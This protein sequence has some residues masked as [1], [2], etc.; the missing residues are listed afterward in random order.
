MPK[1]CHLPDGDKWKR[2]RRRKEAKGMRT[3]RAW[4]LARNPLK[5]R[6]MAFGIRNGFSVLIKE[7]NIA[8]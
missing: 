2:K 4:K 6:N 5:G 1:A 7:F 8:N 3:Q